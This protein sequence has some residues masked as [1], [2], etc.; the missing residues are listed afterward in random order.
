MLIAN[1]GLTSLLPQLG[2][3]PSTQ[4]AITGQPP[5]PG[6]KMTDAQIIAK[7]PNPADLQKAINSGEIQMNQLSPKIQD[8]VKS[9]HAP[10]PKAT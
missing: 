6:T 3:S 5:P 1:G 2:P 7:Y 9:Y 8:W 4:Q 10:V